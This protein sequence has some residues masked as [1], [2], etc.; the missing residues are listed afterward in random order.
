MMILMIFL[1]L[2]FDFFDDWRRG[3]IAFRRC[4]FCLGTLIT[5]ILND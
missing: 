2:F 3:M 4:G 5:L 1:N